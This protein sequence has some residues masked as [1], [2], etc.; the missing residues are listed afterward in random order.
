[1]RI[2]PARAA[3]A[4]PIHALVQRAY[5]PYVARIGIRPGPMDD[6]YVEKVA[7]G[8]AFVAEDSDIVGLIVLIE[9]PDHLLIENVAVDS[10]RQ[11][12]GIGRALLAFAEAHARGSGT[13]TLRLYTNVAMTENIAFYSRLGYREVDRRGEGGF[14]RVFFAKQL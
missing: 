11:G 7:S 14:E 8:H 3:D 6:D 2:R 12:E 10:I 4:E 1:M 5:G 9:K 13:L